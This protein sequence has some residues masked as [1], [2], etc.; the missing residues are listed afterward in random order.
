MKRKEGSITV[1]PFTPRIFCK[2]IRRLKIRAVTVKEDTGLQQLG[3]QSFQA[4]LKQRLE[5]GEQ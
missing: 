2:L 1:Q 3:R 4:R 5:E